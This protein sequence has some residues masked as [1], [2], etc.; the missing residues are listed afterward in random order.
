ME[1]HSLPVPQENIEVYTILYHIEIALRELI[2][3]ALSKVAGSR[4]YSNRLTGDILQKYKDGRRLESQIPWTQ[5]IPHNPIY[6]VDFPHL[7]MIIENANNWRDAF[8]P[9]FVRKEVV[10]GILTEIEP[11][12]NK[13]AHNRKATSMDVEVVRGAISKLSNAIGSA[14]FETLVSRCTL[15]LD[16]PE[17]LGQLLMEAENSLL[18]CCKFDSLDK[19]EVWKSVHD[20][21]WF[22]ES[23]LGE[24]IDKIEVFFHTVDAY[25][26]LPRLRGSG[27]KIENW[28]K[29]SDIELKYLE[30][31]VQFDTILSKV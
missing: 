27:P 29:N 30:A 15:A 24:K 17:Q 13:I 1:T 19:L 3:E 6:Y 22:D 4:W 14:Y 20:A 10:V 26:L 9:I 2:V 28:V 11:I 23:Y 8:K 5:F 21:W 25:S 16:I 7:R 31:K 18:I 12:R